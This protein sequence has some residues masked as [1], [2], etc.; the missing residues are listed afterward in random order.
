MVLTLADMYNEGIRNA[1]AEEANKILQNP[2]SIK[3]I[4]E[5]VLQ[6]RSDWMEVDY[7]FI[8]H[9]DKCLVWL[10][11][12]QRIVQSGMFENLPTVPL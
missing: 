11:P 9:V 7:Y 10:E 2:E 4:A 3:N 1:I 12:N 5:L 8:N 6:R